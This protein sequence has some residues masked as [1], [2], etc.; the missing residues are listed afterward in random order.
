[1]T[2]A[3]DTTQL[4][5]GVVKFGSWACLL[6]RG[7]LSRPGRVHGTVQA[8]DTAVPA[9]AAAAAVFITGTLYCMLE[10]LASLP[11]AKHL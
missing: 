4:L 11:L 2:L 9:A 8:N 3:C 10:A 6:A 5:E 7:K 1:M